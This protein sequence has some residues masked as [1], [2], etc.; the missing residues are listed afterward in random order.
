MCRSEIFEKWRDIA[1]A[2]LETDNNEG[3]L[4]GFVSDENSANIAYSGNCPL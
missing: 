1:K 2:K 3:R 4:Q